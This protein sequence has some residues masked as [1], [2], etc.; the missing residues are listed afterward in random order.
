MPS[1]RASLY[2]DIYQDGVRRYEY[3]QLY[4]EPGTGSAV[5]AANRETLLLAEAICAKRLVELRTGAYSLTEG[6]KRDTL[7]LP[8]FRHTMEQRPLAKTS[9]R[10]WHN[11]LLHL[12]NYATE[13]TTFRHVTPQ[14]VQGFLDH[15]DTTNGHGR[16]GASAL[17]SEGT[18]WLYY[19]KFKAVIHQAMKDDIIVRDPT[20]GITRYHKQESRRV[21]LSFEEVRRLAATPCADVELRRAFLFSCLTGLR[22]SDILALTWGEVSQHGAFTRLTFR[23]QKTGGQEYI[24]LTPQAVA[25]MGT[26]AEPTAHVFAMRYTAET[27]PRLQRWAADAGITKTG[28]TFHSARHTFAVMMLELGADLYTVSKL[29]GHREIQTTQIYAHVIDK[30]KQ[31][32]ALLVPSLT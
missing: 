29:L 18:R 14:W 22:R 23:Q 13:Q 25:F 2:L 30:T 1:G 27:S 6:E 26:P 31:A 9:R 17:I 8:Y 19:S 28:I 4:L 12:S 7:L 5:K 11:A 10:L 24:D 32:A 21:F 20:L 16:R 15:L 3:L